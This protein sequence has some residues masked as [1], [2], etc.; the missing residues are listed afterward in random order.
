MMAGALDL[1]EEKGKPMGVA[2]DTL[3]GEDERWN[4]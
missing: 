4:A 2:K 3:I 1:T